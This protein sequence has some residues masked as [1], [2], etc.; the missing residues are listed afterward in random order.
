MI[1]KGNLKGG[2]FH[3][4]LLGIWN[5]QPEEMIDADTITTFKKA[6]IVR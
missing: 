5:G 2:F 3:P 6:L 4:V 1:F